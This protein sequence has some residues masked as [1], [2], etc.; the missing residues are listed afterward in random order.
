MQAKEI[1]AAQGRLKGLAKETPLEPSLFFSKQLGPGSNVLLKL[2][3]QQHT[4]SFKFRGAMNRVLIL[5][6]EE[7]KA[8]VITASAGNHG[9]GVGYGAKM[10]GIQATIVVPAITPKKKIE[11]I[12]KYGVKLIIFGKDYDAAEA[13]ARELQKETGMTFI[14]AYNDT[15]VIAGQGTVGLEIFRQCPCT[16][17]V[18]APIGGGGLL[19]GVA[20]SARITGSKAK[21]YG[22]QSEASPVMYAS[23]K[24]GRILEMQVED[25]IADGLHGGIEK[26]SVTFDMVK[27]YANGVLLVSEDEIKRAIALFYEHHNQLAEGAGA[28][29]LAALL[30]YKAQFK[31]KTVSVVISGGNI[32]SDVFDKIL[33]DFGTKG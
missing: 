16:D 11:A 3:N 19:V 29:G 2:E 4:G 22:V 30:R 33:H 15:A 25:S 14:S 28:V 23:L 1:L 8:G 27:K 32:N 21:F 31:G 18:L 26:G 17:V 5:T 13:K 7:K 6:D 20:M 24:A 12:R 9:Q 10:L